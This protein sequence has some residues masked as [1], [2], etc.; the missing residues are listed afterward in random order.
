MEECSL[1]AAEAAHCIPKSLA[2]GR[3]AAL[4]FRCSRSKGGLSDEFSAR[5]GKCTTCEVVRYLVKCREPCRRCIDPLPASQSR[6]VAKSSPPIA[7]NRVRV[8]SPMRRHEI[9]RPGRKAVRLCC[10]ALEMRGFAV[11]SKDRL[12][13]ARTREERVAGRGRD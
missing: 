7:T 4:L 10:V 2:R 3:R 8:A 12:A 11:P 6:R 13:Y 9:D 1:A 5:H